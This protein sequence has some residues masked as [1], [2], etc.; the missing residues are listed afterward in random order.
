MSTS[1]TARLPLPDHIV[2]GRDHKLQCPIHRDGALVT[3]TEGAVAVYDASGTAVVPVS[4][5]TVE[6]GVATFVVPGATTAGLRRGAGWR[7]EWTLTLPDGAV[8]TPRN[9]ASLVKTHL[10]PVITDADIIARAPSLDP[11]T[12][13]RLSKSTTY[14]WAIDEA[15]VEIQQWLIDQGNRPN[16]IVAPHSLRSIHLYLA[17]ALI[18]GDMSTSQADAYH[19]QAERYREAYREARDALKL[20]YDEDD[21]GRADTMRPSYPTLW[22]Y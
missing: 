20:A 12:D 22:L 21:D 4:P 11:K 5:A 13:K 6:D 3:P 10:Y 14:Q 8:I 7:I 19:A 1:Y 16:L 9:T 18:Y 15:W 2:Q 17:L